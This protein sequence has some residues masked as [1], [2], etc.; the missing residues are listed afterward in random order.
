MAASDDDALQVLSGDDQ[1]D[2]AY[3]SDFEE[4][5]ADS[6]EEEADL[7]EEE[8]DFDDEDEED[9]DSDEE[10]GAADGNVEANDSA[11]HE[12][13]REALLDYIG[14]GNAGADGDEE[15]DDREAADESDSSEDEAPPRNTVGEI[16]LEFYKD[17]E[18]IG[19]DRAGRKLKKQAR[20]DQL[21]SFLDRSDDPKDWHKVYDEYNDEYVELTKE[22]MGM[23][24][25]IRQ[26]KLPHAEVDAYQPYVDWFDWDGKG[27]PLSN[28]P[29]PK[30]RFIPSKWEAKKVVKLV[31]ALRKGW[32]KLD[33][34]K[35]KPR[36]YLMWG[37]DLK[38]NEKT[39]NGLAY[40]P[41]PK[42]KLPGHEESYNPPVEYIPSE[43]EINSY[44]LM[45]EEDRPK[46]IPKKFDSLRHVPAYAEFIKEIFERCLDL[47]LCPRTRKKRLNIDPD[48]LLPKLP[49]PKDL[50]P[51]PTTCFLEYKGHTGAVSS[52]SADPTGEWLLSGSRDGTVRVWEVQTGRC[53]KVWDMGGSVFCV[54][55]NP[56]PALPV[57][58]IAVSNDVVLLDPEV[59]DE[60]VQLNIAKLLAVQP[61]TS[62]PTENTPLIGWKR[63]DKLRGIQLSHQQ[64]VVRVSWHNKGDYFVS[65]SP[66]GNNRAVLVHQLSKQQSQNPF[67]KHHG[68]VADVL[69]HPARPFMFVAT[70]MHVRVYN[71]AK[72]E[73]SKKLITGLQEI[74]SMALHSGGDNLILGSKGAKLCWFDMD[75]SVK[76]YKTIK[77]HKEDINA[78]AF[79]KSYPLFASCSD[80]LSTHVFHGMVYSDLM[81]NPLIVPLKILHGHQKG[82]RSPSGSSM[83]QSYP[84]TSPGVS[85]I[86]FHPT[87]PWLFTA[88]A[89]SVIKLFCN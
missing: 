82:E 42:A 79:H 85:D 65:V 89:D 32:I 87:Q 69:F 72:Q 60:E 27:H 66:D 70:K 54:A 33:K 58:A 35:E 16:P 83:L 88:G 76:P 62:E 81:Q 28:A 14:N 39:A 44:Q 18:H 37:D 59:G 55:W 23:I 63:H 86:K 12:E 30:R 41:A 29:E 6:G 49:K 64:N 26:G 40:I 47:Y 43:E 21:D 4:E 77:N 53:K 24:S 45:Y 3:S 71:L 25:R 67:R 51:Y 9:E 38:V 34:P 10:D 84:A 36:F 13:I 56:N 74:S 31:R 11:N 8:G 50:Q 5:E 48:S 1:D 52:I 75:L 2:G 7:D 78:V 57:V 73:L 19:Y 17:E 20:K 68:R 80:D 61:S 46:F 22:E 15:S